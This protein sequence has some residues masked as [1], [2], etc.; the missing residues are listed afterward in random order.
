MKV[1]IFLKNETTPIGVDNVYNMDSDANFVK[2]VC[3][4][5]DTYLFNVEVVHSV[6]ATEVEA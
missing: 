1:K 4:N 2:I 3:H 6:I 5:D